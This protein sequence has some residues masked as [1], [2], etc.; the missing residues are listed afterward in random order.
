MRVG[1]VDRKARNI[2]ILWER[3]QFILSI[4][5]EQQHTRHEGFKPHYKISGNTKIDELIVFIMFFFQTGMYFSS[6]FVCAVVLG[7][8]VVVGGVNVG[9]STIKSDLLA[10]RYNASNC[11]SSGYE[12]DRI[13]LSSLALLGYTIT[14]FSPLLRKAT[15]GNA[16]LVAVDGAGTICNISVGDAFILSCGSFGSVVDDVV[17]V[18]EV[19]GI[20]GS[21]GDSINRFCPGG[22]TVRKDSIFISKVGVGTGTELVVLMYSVGINLAVG[23]GTSR[24]PNIGRRG[25]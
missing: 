22:P 14:I 21:S 12:C 16:V 11:S 20:S 19:N 8:M 3:V 17:V 6:V 7:P 5:Q 24:E 13:F 1:T 18:V 23:F 2:K 10:W 4:N 9:K 25:A 15:G